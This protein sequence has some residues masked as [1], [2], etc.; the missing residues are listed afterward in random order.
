MQ[1]LVTIQNEGAED[2]TAKYDGDTYT[3]PAG[4]SSTFP[5]DVL[6]VWMG[7]PAIIN[8]HGGRQR[9][10]VY[11]KLASLYG[12]RG[13]TG[14]DPELLPKLSAWTLEGE[15]IITILDDPKGDTYAPSV[16]GDGDIASLQRQI[17]QMSALLQQRV[18]G[19]EDTPDRDDVDDD[20][21]LG[22]RSAGTEGKIAEKIAEERETV[23]LEGADAPSTEA[24]TEATGDSSTPEL[25]IPS[26]APTKPPVGR[27]SKSATGAAKAP[28]KRAAKPRGGRSA[29]TAGRRRATGG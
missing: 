12:A 28:A 22:S 3:I 24:P 23:P 29:G 26:D 10:E 21:E 14:N 4:E 8:E 18:A 15:Q 16:D 2:F 9:D 27:S 1:Q 20:A 13:L 17:D 5:W 6:L 11:S 25:D 7:D 19:L